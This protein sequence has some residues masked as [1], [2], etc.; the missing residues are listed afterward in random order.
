MG[1]LKVSGEEKLEK[2]KD[3]ARKLV[4]LLEDAQCG[5]FTWHMFLDE[6][7]KNINALYKGD[8]KV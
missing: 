4:A 8:F 2:L 5:L 6:R 3:E 1:N 7:I